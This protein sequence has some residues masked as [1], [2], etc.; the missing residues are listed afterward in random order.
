MTI[1]VTGGA[2]YIGSHTVKALQRAGH[3]IYI[4]DSLEH[5]SQTT[6]ETLGLADSFIPGSIL[7]T[8]AL[9]QAFARASF[10][11]VI[12]FAAYIE[13]GE[14]VKE[15]GRFFWNN[16]AGSIN[17]LNAMRAHDVH[18]LVF[19]STAAVYGEPKTVPITEDA[20][21]A[22]TNP[23]GTSKLLI[24]QVISDLTTFTP[25]KATVLRYFNA[26]GADPDGQL[27]ENHQPETHLIPLVLQ[28]AAG[29][30][31]EIK[32][33]GTDY[34][35]P[36]GTAVRDYIHVSDLAQAHVMAL[37][38]QAKADTKLR[39][40]N[41]GTGHGYSVKEVI[42]ACR[43]A[44]KHPIPTREEARRPGDPAQLVADSS[45][46]QHELGWQP[47]HSDLKTI[48]MTAWN[49]AKQAKE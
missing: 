15:P 29:K 47:N 45:Q 11:A 5:G 24:E 32:I 35:T 20:A 4:F 8:E 6:I 9:D 40:Y 10:D 14:S 26:C 22:P 28:V 12:H 48:T 18:Q 34:P 38:S 30:R 44:T 19:S 16:T 37:E 41:V 36:D 25:L 33:F 39:R 49:W 13:A 21:K 3:T 7:D 23:Y 27:G 2:G 46:I 42:E 1:L 43:Q 17:L 31:P